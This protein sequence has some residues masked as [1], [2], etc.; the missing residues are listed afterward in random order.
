M[1]R[2]I[3]IGRL[4]SLPED[5]RISNDT[6]KALLEDY[7][8]STGEKEE[9]IRSM[10]AEDFSPV[11][12]ST[13]HVLRRG[14]DIQMD[15]YNKFIEGYDEYIDE[16]LT[17][18]RRNEKRLSEARRLMLLIFDLPADYNRILY[19]RYIRRFSRDEL[20]DYLHISESAYYRAHSRAIE[21]LMKDFELEEEPA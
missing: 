16:I 11:S 15:F 10:Y 21:M 13:G 19:L 18:Y 7:R 2:N 14:R 20:C 8:N 5:L 3:I 1:N 6:L 4:Q 9:M 12:S 17:Q